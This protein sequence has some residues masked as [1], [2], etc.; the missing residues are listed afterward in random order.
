MFYFA[1]LYYDEEWVNE[2]DRR[3]TCEVLFVEYEVLFL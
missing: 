3:L 1:I 2:G